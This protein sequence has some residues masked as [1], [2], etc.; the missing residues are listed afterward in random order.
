M[1]R[2]SHVTTS[3]AG[4]TAMLSARIHAKYQTILIRA[5]QARHGLVISHALPTQAS[6][7]MTGDIVD[8]SLTE[9]L[10]ELDKVIDELDR[11]NENIRLTIEALEVG[12]E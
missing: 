10:D 5:R 12:D 8:K 11:L 6:P 3:V 2:A 7:S 9:L 4:H 1:N